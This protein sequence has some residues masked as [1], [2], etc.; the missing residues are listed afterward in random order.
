MVVAECAVGLSQG[1]LALQQARLVPGLHPA[2]G[3]PAASPQPFRQ[4]LE[5][6]LQRTHE[7]KGPG[8]SL[9]Y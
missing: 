8:Q 9:S 2:N 3:C 6:F 7:R 1:E 4:A 5:W